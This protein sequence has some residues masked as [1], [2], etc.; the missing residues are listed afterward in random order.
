MLKRDVIEQA[1]ISAAQRQGATLNSKMI[2]D[3]PRGRLQKK[4]GSFLTL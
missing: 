2:G 3:H 4:N 1:I